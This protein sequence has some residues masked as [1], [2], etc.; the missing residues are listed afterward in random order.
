MPVHDHP[1]QLY[2][3]NIGPLVLRIYYN[4]TLNTNLVSTFT[5]GY[6]KY[7]ISSTEYYVSF[8]KIIIAL[9]IQ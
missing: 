6:L 7:Y 1:L 9:F 2:I 3:S 8:I 5:T 4:Y